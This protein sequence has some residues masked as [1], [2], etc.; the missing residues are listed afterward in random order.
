MFFCKSQ[1]FYFA[2]K[3]VPKSRL[4]VHTGRGIIFIERKSFYTELIIMFMDK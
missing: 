1:C 3:F 4:V 2:W